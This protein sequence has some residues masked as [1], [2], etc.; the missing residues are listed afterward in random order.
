MQYFNFSRLLNKYKSEFIL[1]SQAEGF[2]DDCGDWVKSDL[3]REALDG[4]II[5]FKESKIFRSEGTLTT[6]D[7]RL[8]T[9]KP[10]GRILDGMKVIHDRKLYNVEACTQNSQFTGVY[11]YTLRYVSAY[12]RA[13]PEY[14]ATADI[15]ALEKR[16]DGVSYSQSHKVPEFDAAADIRA[17]KKRL[18]GTSHD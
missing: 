18:D 4:A 10:L 13:V 7:K 12:T 16:L 17:L 5:S 9:T 15:I 8:F 6:N 3:T 2:F 14:D 11:A 1:I